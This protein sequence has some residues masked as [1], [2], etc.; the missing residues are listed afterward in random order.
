MLLFILSLLLCTCRSRY[1]SSTIVNII[2]MGVKKDNYAAGNNICHQ[3]STDDV[4]DTDDGKF[5]GHQKSVLVGVQSWIFLSKRQFKSR[6]SRVHCVEK[7]LNDHF[8]F[9]SIL[10]CI[11]IETDKLSFTPSNA[12]KFL[13]R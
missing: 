4:S 7:I 8:Q 11:I 13:L 2:V 12:I 3:K 6:G 1:G 10:L 9:W 5:Y